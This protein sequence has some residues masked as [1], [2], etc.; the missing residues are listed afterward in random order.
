MNYTDIID[1]EPGQRANELD[2]VPNL[3]KSIFEIYIIY[4]W[5][6]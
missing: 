1:D 4:L 3:L 6:K 2:N 5:G